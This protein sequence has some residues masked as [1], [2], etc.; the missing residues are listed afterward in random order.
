MAFGKGSE[1]M[2]TMPS[3]STLNEMAQYFHKKG[4]FHQLYELKVG[5]LDDYQSRR[6]EEAK[7][8]RKV[9]EASAS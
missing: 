3:L 5:E 2:K 4:V 9:C 1:F 7:R 8:E 6:L